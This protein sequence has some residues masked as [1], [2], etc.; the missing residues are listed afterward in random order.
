[1]RIKPYFIAMAFLIICAG[2]VKA[3]Q[4]FVDGVDLTT[5]KAP[6]TMRILG[7]DLDVTRV[8]VKPDQQ[9]AY[10]MMVSESAKLNVSV[11][12]EPVG[13]CKSGEECR[14][15]VL[16]LGN[17]AWGNYQDLAKGRIKDFHYF[18]FYRPEV[19]GRPVKML[20]MYAQYVSQGYW[21]D[22]HISKV[23]YEKADH[24]LFEK[25]VNSVVFV[26]KSGT[27][28]SAFDAEIAAGQRTVSSWL[29]LWDNRKCR[30]SHVALSSI[31]KADNPEAGWIEH[32]TKANDFL[33]KNKSRNLVA[34]AFTRSLPGKTDRPIAIL[35]YHSDFPK[36][37]TVVEIVALILEKDGH[38]VITN[39]LPQ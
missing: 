3:Q 33:G 12:I 21:I 18:E 11:F 15:H 30:E 2:V 1:M 5:I 28:N 6:W 13:K 39:Y 34:A 37:S 31:T 20:D 16:G 25:L 7:N 23:L 32:C 38:W 17:P 29:M 24:A 19:K 36:R 22:L 10:F 14:D 27:A 8:Q 4:A 9:S 26:P 35:A